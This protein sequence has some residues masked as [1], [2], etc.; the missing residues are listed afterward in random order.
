MGLLAVLVQLAAAI[1]AI[2]AAAAAA[3]AATITQFVYVRCALLA[4]PVLF[5]FTLNTPEYRLPVYRYINILR[6]K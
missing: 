4:T 5:M 6:K 2:A 1:A 3:A